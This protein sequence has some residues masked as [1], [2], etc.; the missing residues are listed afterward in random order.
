MVLYH[1]LKFQ[2]D[3]SK[4]LEENRTTD[5]QTDSQ[6]S[7]QTDRQTNRQTEKLLTEPS[8]IDAEISF[9]HLKTLNR[10]EQERCRNE[11]RHLTNKQKGVKTVTS[12]LRWRRLTIVRENP[13]FQIA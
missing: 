12:D 1:V 2:R 4:D 9:R 5:K 13:Y 6:T 3:L 11:F 10:T 8:K 7:R